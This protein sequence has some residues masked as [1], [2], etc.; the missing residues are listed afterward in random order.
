VWG[1]A[2]TASSP[3]KLPEGRRGK[4]TH[5]CRRRTPQVATQHRVEQRYVAGP[6]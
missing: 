4:M 1:L 2:P 3:R 6:R 5:S